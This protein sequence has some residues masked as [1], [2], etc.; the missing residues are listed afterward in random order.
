MGNRHAKLLKGL[1][2]ASFFSETIS[3]G[4]KRKG[5]QPVPSLSSRP[6]S[7]R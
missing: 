7:W 3:I 4:R 2:A 5:I 6:D 1:L